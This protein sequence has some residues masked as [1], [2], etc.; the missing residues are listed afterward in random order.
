MASVWL[1]VL[2]K[3]PWMLMERVLVQCWQ[4]AE[5]MGW[6][7]QVQQWLLSKLAQALNLLLSLQVCCFRKLNSI[8]ATNLLQ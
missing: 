6:K 4:R 7:L 2:Q 1:S 3:A 5:P 8:E